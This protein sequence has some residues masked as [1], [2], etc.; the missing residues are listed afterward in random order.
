MYRKTRR[1]DA[2]HKRQ[3]PFLRLFRKL[4]FFVLLVFLFYAVFTSFFANTFRVD[5]VSMLPGCEPGDRL[6]ISPLWYGPRIPFTTERLPGIFNQRR[7]DIVVLSPPYRSEA[8]FLE[9]LF[10]PFLDFFTGR[11][12][13]FS[14]TQ[15]HEWD[16]EYVLR[17]IIALPGD[18]V[19]IVAGE[20]YV[21]PLGT[22][23]FVSEFSLSLSPYEIVRETLPEGWTDS[24][25]LSAYNEVLLGEDEYFVLADNRKGSLDSRLWGPIHKDRIV[26]KVLFRYW[27]IGKR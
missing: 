16:N 17:R 13:H 4:L 2:L 20:A 24:S 15:R 5:S 6:V 19:R 27:P 10:H 22:P 9:K 23:D 21:R 26:T 3:H 12:K 8:P 14:F 7:G 1:F 11:R 25:P 18:A